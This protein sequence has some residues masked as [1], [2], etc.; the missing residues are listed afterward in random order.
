[1]ARPRKTLDELVRDGTFLA[2][3][4]EGLLA[5]PILPQLALAALQREYIRADDERVRRV[6]AREFE[7]IV[8]A[9]AGHRAT[10][11]ASPPV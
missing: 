5:G 9:L 3:R 11:T 2:R 6:I 10:A 7:H 4:H 1:M 8:R